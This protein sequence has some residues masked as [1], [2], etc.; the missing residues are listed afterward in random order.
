MKAVVLAF[1]PAA[2]LAAVAGLSLVSFP[3]G[4]RD[5]GHATVAFRMSWM[6]RVWRLPL[7]VGCS[8]G[9]STTEC[10]D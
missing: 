1:G 2:V 7:P 6:V 3:D 5:G 9:R 8:I 4:G 10:S